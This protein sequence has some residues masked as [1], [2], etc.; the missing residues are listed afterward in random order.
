[1]KCTQIIIDLTNESFRITNIIAI[2][3]KYLLDKEAKLSMPE[4]LAN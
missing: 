1:M 2:I 3:F 4:H